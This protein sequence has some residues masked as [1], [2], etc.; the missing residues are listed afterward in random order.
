LPEFSIALA[1]QEL[2]RAKSVFIGCILSSTLLI[3]ICSVLLFRFGA[4]L[5]E[6][7]THRQITFDP[8]LLQVLLIGILFHGIWSNAA[9]PAISMNQLTKISFSLVISSVFSLLMATVLSVSMGYYAF[10]VGFII[11]EM[12]M[13]PVA[14]KESFK[15]LKFELSDVYHSIKNPFGS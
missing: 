5:Y 12:M 11:T 6:F 9:L 15:V 3:L 8:M 10:A 1:K 4:P 2:E 13:I 14:F 7:W